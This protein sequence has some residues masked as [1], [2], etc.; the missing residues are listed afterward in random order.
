MK[1]GVKIKKIFLASMFMIFAMVLFLTT[2]TV[3]ADINIDTTV[4]QYHYEC[5]D[6]YYSDGYF[7]HSAT[8][9]DP[10]LATLSILMSK[11]S[12]NPGNPNNKD[13]T[14][15]YNEQSNRVKGFFELIGFDSFLPN[16]DYKRR[17]SF[18]TIGVGCA[19]KKVGD[20]T[21][22]G[23]TV[24]S[25]GYF[26][27]WANN[28]Y[29]GDGTKSDY[30]HEGWYN[31]AN[32]L[33]SHLNKYIADYNITGKIKL[34]MAG[35]SR[36]GAVTN[37]A[38]GLLDNDINNNSFKAKNVSISHDD[39]YA[40]TFEAPQGANINSKTVKFPTD[41][42]YNNIFNVVNPND[43][44]TKVAMKGY[45][46]TRFGIDKFILTKL[47]APA[48]YDNARSVYKKIY[49][50]SH[51]DIN[52]YSADDFVVKGITGDKIAGLIA[53]TAAGGFVGGAIT[54]VI[55]EK[56]TGIVSVDNTKANYDS[57]IVTNMFLDEL[58]NS[59]GSRETYCN[60]YQEFT[61]DLMLTMMND[62][63]AD[64][65]DQLMKL[66][67]NI[68]LESYMRKYGMG[69]LLKLVYPNYSET[70]ISNL[71]SLAAVVA[72]IYIER[73]NE[74]I[75][76]ITNIG[77]IFQ[78]HDTEINVI[79]LECQDDYYINAYNK[80]HS[81][82]QLSPVAL[83]D[84]ASLVHIAFYGFNDVQVYDVNNN[85]NKVVDVSGH[86]LGKSD[87]LKCDPGYAVGYYSYITEE[88]M[89]LYLPLNKK[90]N[91]SFKSYS[92]KLHHDVNYKTVLQNITASTNNPS[93]PSKN[94]K[95]W[96]NSNRV[97]VT[98]DVKS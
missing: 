52:K 67:I 61:R 59:I 30:M 64:E 28:V 12:M 39:L 87:V 34:W 6:I 85:N 16:D 8:E 95:A 26:L 19:K 51:N 17:T 79:H 29:L 70:A 56:M 48:A 3:F 32:K 69:S 4:K 86:V 22:I 68:L 84:N 49:S 83:L 71:V 7:A 62:D 37:I 44:V 11:Y 18:S 13:D 24:R 93:L 91:V 66:I 38:A 20:Y 43:L 58:V 96:F 36:G 47:Y 21:V 57:N 41:D 75:S 25:G 55:I 1:Y 81:D 35:F 23:I 2:N 76:L 90:L 10:H 82:D 73:P 42:I 80:K 63:E 60:L 78:N 65:K 77:N 54:G 53:G 27:E 15:W 14:D 72:K 92:K 40:Y 31:A 89:E 97:N 33:I 5:D 9:Y 46:F 74:L 94:D 50:E 45:G 88:K 98:I